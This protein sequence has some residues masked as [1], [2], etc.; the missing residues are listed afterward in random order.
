MGRPYHQL[1]IF[2]ALVFPHPSSISSISFSLCRISL[3]Q[4]CPFHH[5]RASFLT[6][7]YHCQPQSPHPQT[8]LHTSSTMDHDAETQE[9]ATTEAARFLQLNWRVAPKRASTVIAAFHDMIMNLDA[10]GSYFFQEGC[11]TSDETV[12]FVEQTTEAGYKIW[13]FLRPIN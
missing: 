6:L 11:I 5:D 13:V 10:E 1:G 9:Q 3:S 7:A 4:P 12:Q 2:L 8:H